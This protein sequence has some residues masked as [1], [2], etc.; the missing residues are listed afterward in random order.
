MDWKA[1]VNSFS[2]PFH[3]P[4]NSLST[5]LGHFDHSRAEIAILLNKSKE[6]ISKAK[7]NLSQK[8]FQLIT[9]ADKT[10][11][12]HNK[13]Y[14]I[15][16]TI[17]QG[18]K[19]KPFDVQKLLKST[20]LSREE[21]GRLIATQF[22]TNKGTDTIFI[23][24]EKIDQ[25]S[26]QNDIERIKNLTLDS[27]DRAHRFV[28]LWRTLSWSIE[29]LDLVLTQFEVKGISSGIDAASVAEIGSLCILEDKLNVSVQVLCALWG[30][31]PI[32]PSTPNQSALLDSLFNHDN[33]VN[34]DGAYPKDSILF[35]HP[36]LVIDGSTAS[37][38][39]LSGRLMIGLN[40]SDNEVLTLI[41]NLAQP[42]GILNIDSATESERG[43]NLTIQ[44]L[45]LLYRHSK[46]AEL[47]KI[48]IDELFKLM[49]LVE[50][51][52]NGHIEN[53]V[54]LNAVLEFHLWWETTSYSLDELHF[55][56]ESSAIANSNSFQTKE[57][58]AQ[59]VLEQTKTENGLLF[60]D[61]IFA[62]FDDITEE[63]SKAI[64]AA[65]AT[66]IEQSPDN[67]GTNYWLRPTFDSDTPIIIPPGI[68]RAETEIRAVLLGYHSKTLI[69]HYISGQLGLSKE[70]II[71]LIEALNIDLNSDAYTLELRGQSTPAVV[72]PQLIEKL[73]PI[74]VLFKDGMFN[75][76]GVLEYVFSH[77]DLFEIVSI[78][79]I[80]VN[81]IQKLHL[82]T[83]FMI[84]QEDQ[85]YNIDTLED[86]LNAF[87]VAHQFKNV[88]QDKLASL[89]S[90]K[91]GSLATIH[92]IMENSSNALKS[93][94]QLQ[95]LEA[96]TSYLGVG[97]DTLPLIVSNEYDNLDQAT[98]A[99]LAAFRTKYNS[100]E[101]REEKLE[102]Y[103][104]KIR[105]LKRRAL[106]NFLIHSDFPQFENENDLF[107]YFLID[108]ELEG[109]ARTSRLVA[110]T[111]SLQ[112]YVH[113]ILLNLEQDDK[114]L[115]VNDKL[116][117][118]ADEL[119]AEEWIWRKNYRVW[120]AN[121]K[122]FLYPENYI[123]PGF[124]DNKSSLFEELESDL[125]Q[126]EINE[127]TVLE[128]YA[129]YMR[130]F[131]ELAH[132]KIAGSFHEKDELT[133]TD[134]LHLFGVT[135]D[136]PPIYYY[137]NRRKYLF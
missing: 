70:V 74:R 22:V 113:R 35:I 137:R 83:Q 134:T 1:K 31:I 103:N 67:D 17:V 62:F 130:G 40:R 34:T 120:E 89:L 109:C 58:V 51:L 21:L 128:A 112:F 110:A 76:T 93:L 55:I 41:Q 114:E 90:C 42:L 122:V 123:E 68:T 97:G 5:Y 13:I 45:S 107:N 18:A 73:I 48:S 121:R 129:K 82:F 86:V 88:N 61:T 64:I 8:E 96:L 95:K 10:P 9:V 115:G 19:I 33:I 80:S 77:L 72:I 65:N 106:T 71:T 32:V 131:D 24:G 81:N 26:I 85:S 11:A 4:L 36:V 63:Q 2:Q 52:E 43:F 84:K 39:F 23:L 12:F 78:D 94:S 29:E 16:F 3:L 38:E 126:L 92:P 27:L 104:D 133:K 25:N 100:E 98:T 135:S 101:E 136:E 99:V 15:D 20:G 59:A 111:M 117:V 69:P 54:H 102:P 108:V 127:D 46:M 57:V 118:L 119:P 91:K 50:S 56:T 37:A 87:E 28:R 53:L 116:H 60:A 7:L 125:L 44:N 66:I 79:S 75:H 14:D 49:Q 47:L 124:R 6:D 132:L 30:T 105:G